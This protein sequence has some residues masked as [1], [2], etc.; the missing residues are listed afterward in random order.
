MVPLYRVLLR[1]CQGVRP[2]EW[3]GWFSHPFGAVKSRGHMQYPAFSP[4]ILFL[5][6]LFR[7]GI[8]LLLVFLYLVVH[9]LPQLC[10]YTI[11][12]SFLFVCFCLV[13]YTFSVFCCLRKGVSTGKP[14]YWIPAYLISL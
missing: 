5:T 14:W 13:I 8:W 10:L 6:W 2:E 12:F 7:N 3:L 9:N 4:D 11:V 1:V